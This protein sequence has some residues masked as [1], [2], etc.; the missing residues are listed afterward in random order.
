MFM[1]NSQQ[2]ALAVGS[3]AR[4]PILYR[5]NYGQWS[6]RFTNHIMRYKERRLLLKS[7]KEG[8]YVFKEILDPSNEGK[9][10]MQEEEDLS[11][12]ELAQ[13]ETDIKL[14]NILMYGLSNEIYNSID[15]N[16]TSK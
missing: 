7:L 13:S 4:P 6:S 12:K 10:K 8:P 2:D 3:D 16:Q 11:D 1:S 9:M 14:K 15:S 5:G